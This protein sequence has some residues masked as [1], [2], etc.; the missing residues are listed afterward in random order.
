[1]NPIKN[2][3]KVNVSSPTLAGALTACIWLAAGALILSFALRFS[4]MQETSLPMSSLIVHGCA[5]LAGGFSSGRR[6]GRKGWYYGGALGLVYAILIILIGFLSI[7]AGFSA[8]TWSLLTIVIPAGS[9]GGMIG[10]NLKK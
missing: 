2:V 7:N 9:L 3:S 8:Q 10:V 5:S 6:S 1:M 4:G